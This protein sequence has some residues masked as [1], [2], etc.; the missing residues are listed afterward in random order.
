MKASLS[1]LQ[2][3]RTVLG[4][5]DAERPAVE[6]SE[7]GRTVY[8]PRG[9]EF[10]KR[11]DLDLQSRQ[12]KS[13][14]LVTGQIGVGKSSELACYFRMAKERKHLGYPVYCDLEKQESPERCRATGVILT[15][16]RDCWGALNWYLEDARSAGTRQLRELIRIRDEIL[17]RLIDYLNGSRSADGNEVVFRF[18][19]ME[20]TVAAA[21]HR[22]NAALALV[23]ERPRS[24]RPFPRHRTN[25][26]WRRMR[27]SFSSIN[28]CG[29]F[30]TD[31]VGPSS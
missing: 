14:V 19:G 8:E 13:R 2:E 21:E 16:L 1:D 3:L 10:L 5:L 31:S 7:V 11:L 4:R 9:D 22:K 25:S 12:G 23:L 6:R 30:R 28:C 20:F 18:G 15:M 24:T 17:T 27:L 26:E 29:G